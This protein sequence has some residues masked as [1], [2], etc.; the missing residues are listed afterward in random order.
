M[1]NFTDTPI[2]RDGWRHTDPVWPA[3]GSRRTGRALAD[4]GQLAPHV[5]QDAV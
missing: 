4:A 5:Q 1:Q 2:D 3:L